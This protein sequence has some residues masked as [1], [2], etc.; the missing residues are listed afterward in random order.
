MVQKKKK[1][2]RKKSTSNKTTN[3]Q[4]LEEL[5]IDNVIIE[6]MEEREDQ[7]RMLIKAMMD[8]Q[9]QSQDD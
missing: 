2:V 6:R 7:N 5:K 1:T 9:N 8:A 3:R 4:I